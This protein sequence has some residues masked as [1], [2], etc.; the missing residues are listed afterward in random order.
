MDK[1]NPPQDLM[2]TLTMRYVNHGAN[3]DLVMLDKDQTW[4]LIK[5]IASLVKIETNRHEAIRPEQTT[6]EGFSL[7]PQEFE[8]RMVAAGITNLPN[9]GERAQT[10]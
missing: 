4:C 9:L 5:M 8:N 2:E 1:I 6:W 7:T 3:T 10:P